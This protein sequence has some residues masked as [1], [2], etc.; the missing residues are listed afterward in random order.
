MDKNAMTTL[1]DML[2]ERLD[3]VERKIAY[4]DKHEPKE[5]SRLYVA[6][7]HYLCEV[8]E[9]IE[10]IRKDLLLEVL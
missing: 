6:Q 1:Y 7:Y 3:C 9:S 4:L 5:F 8:Q 10:T 2:T